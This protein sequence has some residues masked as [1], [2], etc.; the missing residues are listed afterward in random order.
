[1][2]IHVWWLC[3]AARHLALMSRS[4]RVTDESLQ[5]LFD[6]VPMM[7]MFFL[8]GNGEAKEGILWLVFRFIIFFLFRV[9]GLSYVVRGFLGGFRRLKTDQDGLSVRC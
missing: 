8:Y 5:G 7:R 1:M 6:K 9:S 4:G 2:V 3:Q